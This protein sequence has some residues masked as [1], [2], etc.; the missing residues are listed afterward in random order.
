VGD[1]CNFVAACV[2]AKKQ[3]NE[4]GAVVSICYLI[5]AVRLRSISVTRTK[6]GEFWLGGLKVNNRCS[7]ELFQP[8]FPAN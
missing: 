4:D 8:V 2:P 1:C 7:T 5:S 6:D 3:R